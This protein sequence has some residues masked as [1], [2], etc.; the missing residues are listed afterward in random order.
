MKSLFTLAVVVVAL[1][2]AAP[3]GAMPIIDPPQHTATP[4]AP[5]PPAPEPA[6]GTPLL[7]VAIVGA[8]AFLT[9]AGAARLVRLPRRGTAA[10]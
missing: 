7:V 8:A 9:G 6:D 3:A 4:A 5:A 10:G 1:A 2:L